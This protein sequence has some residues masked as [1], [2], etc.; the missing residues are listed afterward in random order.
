MKGINGAF[1]FNKRAPLYDKGHLDNPEQKYK[2]RGRLN[3]IYKELIWQ[4]IPEIF[5]ACFSQ[6]QL[7]SNTFSILIT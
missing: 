3:H 7:A 4:I 2:S 5:F 1:C 6:P